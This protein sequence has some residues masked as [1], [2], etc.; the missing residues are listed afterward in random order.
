MKELEAFLAAGGTITVLPE[1]TPIIFKGSSAR[2]ELVRQLQL[3][4]KSIEDLLPIF[5]D[6][7]TIINAYKAVQRKA[8]I[9]KNG[10]WFSLVAPPNTNQVIERTYNEAKISHLIANFMLKNHIVLANNVHWTGYEC[11]LLAITPSFK[12]IEFEI[13]TSRKDFLRDVSK[14]KW[15]KS[16]SVHKHYYVI[17]ENA[18]SS[19]LLDKRPCQ[20]SGIVILKDDNRLETIVKAQ[21]INPNHMKKQ[22]FFN[23]MRLINNRHW[24]L[25]KEK[26]Q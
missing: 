20:K 14:D 9:F 19:D 21:I 18:Y 25:I 2:D 10:D 17:T 8:T 12:A 3:G 26:S 22:E 1:V 11:D 23:V 4:D 15:Q 7:R 16:L 13:K 6:E 24:R 5:G